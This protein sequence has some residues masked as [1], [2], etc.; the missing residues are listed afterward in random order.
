LKPGDH[1]GQGD[2]TAVKNAYYPLWSTAWGNPLNAPNLCQFRT[3]YQP[4]EGICFCE[5]DMFVGGDVFS[6]NAADSYA[7]LTA[8]AFVDLEKEVT[9]F[10][11]PPGLPIERFVTPV[12]GWKDPDGVSLVLKHTGA[13]FRN[14]PPGTYTISTEYDVPPFPE[15]ADTWVVTFHVL[16]H[17]QAHAL[18][19]PTGEFP[20]GSVKCPAGID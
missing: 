9:T 16:P 17:D 1:C 3:F 5:H 20:F 14:L 2:V 6:V 19:R 15:Q 4:P 12:R 8:R 13:V 18:G 10:V 7:G 11:N